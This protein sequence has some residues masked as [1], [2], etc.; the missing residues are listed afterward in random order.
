M[1]ERKVCAMC[2]VSNLNSQWPLKLAERRDGK[3]TVT[4]IEPGFGWESVKPWVQAASEPDIYS[5]L[6]LNGY[7]YCPAGVTEVG[8]MV[9]CAVHVNEKLYT[10]RRPI[11]FT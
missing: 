11:K 7:E 8:G 2:L 6:D 4:R 3:T 1:T 5:I 9:L 10:S